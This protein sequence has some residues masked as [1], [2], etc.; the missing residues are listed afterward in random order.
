METKKLGAAPE[1]KTERW[2]TARG[3]A[4]LVALGVIALASLVGAILI[5]TARQQIFSVQNTRDFLM[6]KVTAEAGVNDAYEQIKT[7]FQGLTVAGTLNEGTYTA[8][9]YV[10]TNHHGRI[11]SVGRVGLAEATVSATIF[12]YER[13]EPPDPAFQ[14]AIC[15]GGQLDISGSVTVNGARLHSNNALTLSGSGAIN[16]GQLATSSVGISLD[17]G[18]SRITGNVQAPAVGPAD[19]LGQISGTKTV[20]AVP[21]V[22]IPK[23]NL[24]RLYAIAQANGQVYNGSQAWNHTFAPQG[25]VVWVNGSIQLTGSGTYSGAFIAT[26]DIDMGAGASIQKVSD[27][28]ALASTAGSIT[29]K[30]N[31]VTGLIYVRAG[32]I[33]VQSSSFTVNGSVICGGNVTGRGGWTLN[34][35]DCSMTDTAS[36]VV[37]TAWE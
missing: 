8:T 21:T 22:Q 30:G 11:V 14:Y 1:R 34:Y 36:H 27:Y 9:V 37:I 13:S 4:M 33:D 32:N 12:D 25:G 28:P 18:A 29:L 24:D 6:A 7:Q 15:C 3:S 19:R 23:L 5:N 20:A 2:H 17:S 31:T 10:E 35:V 26:G 16:A